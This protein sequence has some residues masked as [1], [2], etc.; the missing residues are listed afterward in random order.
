MIYVRIACSVVFAS[1]LLFTLPAAAETDMWTCKRADGTEI[2]TNKTK[3]LTGCG[4]Y[5]LRTELGYVKRSTEEQG[6]AIEARTPTPPQPQAG[7]PPITIVINNMVSPPARA[8]VALPVGEI[9]FEVF[10]MLSV[11]M[12]EAEVLRRAGLPQSTLIGPYALGSPY[13]VWPVFGANRFV[14]SSGDWV[15]ELT[16][17]GGRVL[18]INQFRP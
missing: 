7:M 6:P 11:G 5:V 2:F 9:P 3:G 15:V 17:G 14:Y 16:F 8:D 18:S 4:E 10:R 12:S 1:L 13:P